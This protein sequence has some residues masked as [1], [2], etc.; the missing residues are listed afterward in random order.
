[1]STSI[2]DITRAR[3]DSCS[4][5]ES[6][7]GMEDLE[8]LNFDD[9]KRFRPK[10]YDSLDSDDSPLDLPE[11]SG[12]KFFTIAMSLKRKLSGMPPMEAKSKSHLTAKNNWKNAFR[13]ALKHREDPWERFNL[14]DLPVEKAIRHR[15][16]A[17]TKKWKKDE[18]LV[19]IDTESFNHGA[20]RECF[21]MKKLSNF[22]NGGQDWRSDCN[23]FVAKRYMDDSVT[24]DT[25]FEDVKLQND[26]KLWGEEFNRHNP[27]KKSGYF[28]N[29]RYRND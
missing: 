21:R 14:D 15:Y 13:V 23:N 20:M 19:K 18:A 1:M 10:R 7:S 9:I 24:R 16:N 5:D 27:P 4:S 29:G 6:F 28:S 8:P 22:C 17:L 12:A 26:A 2:I 25:Y 3:M 11:V